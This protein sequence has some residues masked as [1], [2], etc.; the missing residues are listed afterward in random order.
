MST[1]YLRT[2]VMPVVYP[3]APSAY[4]GFDDK[5]NPVVPFLSDLPPVEVMPRIGSEEIIRLN[6]GN[7][8]GEIGRDSARAAVG[9]CFYRAERYSTEEVAAAISL[10]P[11]ALLQGEPDVRT[12][13][14]KC[15]M[16]SKALPRKGA[17]ASAAGR[18][19]ASLV[20]WST[21][22]SRGEFSKTLWVLRWMLRRCPREFYRVTKENAKAAKRAAFEQATG[23][24]AKLPEGGKKRRGR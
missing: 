24:V 17:Q 4:V 7:Y 15:Q 6:V 2:Q 13:L 16:L 19:V 11:R 8:T 12:L 1:Y 23:Q 5:A 14:A 20:G 22:P 9:A 21:L 10:V 3:P 18:K